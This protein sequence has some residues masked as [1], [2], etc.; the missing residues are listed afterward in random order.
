MFQH[1]TA[2]AHP[3][4][5]CRHFGTQSSEALCFKDGASNHQLLKL[6]DQIYALKM[7]YRKLREGADRDECYAEGADL[8]QVS[9]SAVKGWDAEFRTD[10]SLKVSGQAVLCV[11]R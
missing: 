2:L 11:L 5:L 4:C 10:R 1:R 7:V 8:A 9:V 6:V 3:P